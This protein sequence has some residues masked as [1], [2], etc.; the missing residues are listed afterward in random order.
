MQKHQSEHQFEL[1][2]FLKFWYGYGNLSSES[3]VESN[4]L[5]LFISF[6]SSDTQNMWL[7]NVL[8]YFSAWMMKYTLRK[9]SKMCLKWVK[10]ASSPDM[11]IAATTWT[12]WS[13]TV[14]RTWPYCPRRLGISY[15]PPR[16]TRAEKMH[17]LEVETANVFFFNPWVWKW[18]K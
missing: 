12:C 11:T 4:C 10:A 3:A 7:V 8:Q 6:S 9:S 17:F 16:M 15:S 18:Q 5:A 14:C 2:N 1:I 13:S